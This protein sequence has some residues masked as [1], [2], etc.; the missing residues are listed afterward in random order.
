[1][2]RQIDWTKKLSKEDR[3]WAEQFSLNVPLI[4]QNDAEFS[5]PAGGSL[6]GEDLDEEDV[7][8][9][10]EWTV[11]ELKDEL[12]ARGLTVSGT[13]PELAARLRAHDE[14]TGS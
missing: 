11:A 4:Q 3:A 10:E 5:D 9:Y 8:P 12:K 1:M 13:Q 6:A 7:R 14:S 2:S